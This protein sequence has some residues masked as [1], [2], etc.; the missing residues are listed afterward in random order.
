[1]ALISAMIDARNSKNYTQKDIALKTG[2]NQADISKIENGIRKPSIKLLQKIADA[3]DAQFSL[4]EERLAFAV[5][6]EFGEIDYRDN[7]PDLDE[8]LIRILQNSSNVFDIAT[9]F[10]ME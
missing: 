9:D 7:N 4:D 1:M 8:R 2:I 10:K 6:K 3:M 5:R